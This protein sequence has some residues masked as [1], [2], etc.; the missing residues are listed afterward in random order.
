MKDWKEY[1]D[2]ENYL[3]EA[4][5]KAYEMDEAK[6]TSQV[7]G[8]A[9][10]FVFLVAI[11]AAVMV[12]IFYPAP[13][14]AAELVDMRIIQHI[15]SRGN[16]KAV[17]PVGARGLYQIM[18]CVLKEYNQYHKVK[19]S[20]GQMFDP[21]KNTQVAYWYLNV[22]IP[23]L[24]NYYKLP[25]STNSVIRAYNAGIRSVVKGYTPRETRIYLTKYNRIKEARRG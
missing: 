12:I 21:Q 24:L 16:A 7:V 8:V 14:Q 6:R 9:L 3:K 10:I 25:I 20:W 11:F 4:Y 2:A 22:R 13:A 18:P 19:Y 15:E 23:A 5:A 1:N 17:S